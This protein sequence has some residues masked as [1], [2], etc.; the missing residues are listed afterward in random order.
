MTNRWKDRGTNRHSRYPYHQSVGIRSA[1]KHWSKVK[2]SVR[3]R[4]SIFKFY[5][6]GLEYSYLNFIFKFLRNVYLL[7]V[8][9]SATDIWIGAEY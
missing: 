3:L 1:F 9:R 2:F 8:W 7:S 4:I 5:S 6:K